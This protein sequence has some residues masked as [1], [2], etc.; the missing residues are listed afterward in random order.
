[1]EFSASSAVYLYNTKIDMRSSYDRLSQLVETNGLK[2]RSG[3]YFVFIGRSKKKIKI[4]YWDKDSYCLWQKRLEAGSFKI[5]LNGA[6]EKISVAEL[7]EVLSGLEYERI[8]IRKKY[9]DT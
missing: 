5:L 6:I 1:M 2:S 7:K 8:K 4:L 9:S 3:S